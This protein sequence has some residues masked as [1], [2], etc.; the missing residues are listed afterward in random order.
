L[1]DF[2]YFFRAANLALRDIVPSQ[3]H[4]ALR[5]PTEPEFKEYR[6]RLANCSISKLN[7]FFDP[8][9][10]PELLQISQI[11]RQSPI[12]ISV[13]GFPFLLIL[14]AIFSGGKIN[15]LGIIKAELPAFGKGLKAIREALALDKTVQAGFGI[16][17]AIIK[18]TKEE[19]AEL[20]K[21]DPATKGDGGFQGFLVGLQT[22]IESQTRELELSERDLERILRYKANPKKGGWQSRFNKIFGRHFP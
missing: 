7:S 19:Y 21:Q 14:A 4:D 17:G 13:V 3:D 20:M 8:R 22:R 10:S 2:L 11:N 5:E 1:A 12:D 16:R 18:L 9:N 6:K 15:L